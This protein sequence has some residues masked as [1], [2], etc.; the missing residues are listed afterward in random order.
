MYRPKRI[1]NFLLSE[2]KEI[3]PM[4]LLTDSTWFFIGIISASISEI[5]LDIIWRV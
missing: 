2:K 3:N 4:K 1:S 5:L